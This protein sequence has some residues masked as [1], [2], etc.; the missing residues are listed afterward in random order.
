MLSQSRGRSLKE[1]LQTKKLKMG[2]DI[3]TILQ[4]AKQRRVTAL[5][6]SRLQKLLK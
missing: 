5:T 3:T 2:D 1:L 6:S 4:R